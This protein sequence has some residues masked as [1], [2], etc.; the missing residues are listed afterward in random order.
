MRVAPVLGVCGVLLLL[1]CLSPYLLPS[2]YLAVAGAVTEGEVTAKQE[3]IFMLGND[4]WRH[5]GR[6]IAL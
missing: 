4:R 2:A 6:R 1:G 5:V 3:S